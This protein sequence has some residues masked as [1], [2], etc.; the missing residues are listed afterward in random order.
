MC[1]GDTTPASVK[2]H[3]KIGQATLLGA[4]AVSPMKRSVGSQV[5]A[6]QKAVATTPIIPVACPQRSN[7]SSYPDS[8]D[9]FDCHFAEANHNAAGPTERLVAC[10][11]GP[12]EPEALKERMKRA[13]ALLGQKEVQEILRK[14][15]KIEV[16]PAALE[17]LSFIVHQC[18]GCCCMAPII[19]SLQ[20]LFL[21]LL[22]QETTAKMLLV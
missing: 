15:G 10:R 9:S 7:P 2:V 8:L 6:S 16:C 14:E 21:V 17:S 4:G 5:L 11:Y 3:K 1:R 22:G 12:C 18:H 13:V 19:S 20:H